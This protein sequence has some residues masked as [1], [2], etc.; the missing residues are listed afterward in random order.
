ML[1]WWRAMRF[2]C[3][4]EAARN[5]SSILEISFASMA[6]RNCGLPLSTGR[7]AD[8]DF[9]RV[10]DVASLRDS[11]LRVELSTQVVAVH[12]DRLSAVRIEAARTDRRG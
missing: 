1:R 6:I 3:L 9:E 10:G 5:C 8:P 4:R 12:P 11:P 2:R 7:S